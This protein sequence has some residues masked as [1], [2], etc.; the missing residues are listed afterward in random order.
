M[1]SS[2]DDN[3]DESNYSQLSK[4]CRQTVE[5]FFSSLYNYRYFDVFID[6]FPSRLDYDIAAAVLFALMSYYYQY[7]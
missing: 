1:D 2:D 3:I 4:E 5:L 7:L 6:N